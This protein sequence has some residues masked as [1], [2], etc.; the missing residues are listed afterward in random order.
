MANY[1]GQKVNQLLETRAGQYVQEKVDNVLT[2]T[3]AYVDY[4]LP[5]DQKEAEV[6]KMEVPV[7]EQGKFFFWEVWATHAESF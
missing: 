3:E 7:Q 5:E 1:S 6:Q 2:G 4:Y